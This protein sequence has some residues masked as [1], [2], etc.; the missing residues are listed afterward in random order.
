MRLEIDDRMAQKA[1]VRKNALI[2]GLIGRDISLRQTLLVAFAW[3]VLLFFSLYRLSDYPLIWFDEGSHLHVPKAL[4][5]MGAYADYSSEGLRYFGPTN[6]VG[7]TVMLPVAA[8]FKLF[9]IGLI[10]ARLVV[11]LYLLA[12]IYLFHRLASHL[13]GKSLALAGILL[14]VAS[15]GI[16]IVEYGRQVLG[17]VPALVFL[18]SGIL[19]WWSAWS[20]PSWGKLSLAGVLLG[21]S[22]VTKTQFLL[23]V[24]PAIALAWLAN[25]IHY[26]L[27][28]H[29]V[30]LI[31]GVI[32]AFMFA[33]W[34]FVLLFGIDPQAEFGNLALL[35]KTSGSA[36]FVFSL[37]L[38]KRS[39]SELLSIRG[40]FGLAVWVLLYGV[41]LIMPKRVDA[42]KWATLWLMAVIN[43]AWY[44]F[45]SVSWLR[46][47]FVGL[48]FSCLFLG[49][50][51]IELMDGF[52]ARLKSS[53]KLIRSG[54]PVSG[55]DF[56]RF[57]LI[58]IIVGS[59]VSSLG[60]NAWQVLRPRENP[61]ELMADYMQRYVPLTAVVETY[62]P[63]MGFLTNHRYHFPPHHYLNETI[64]SIW[65]EGSTP[66]SDYD[67]IAEERP[68]Y[69]L[70]GEFST[71][72]NFYSITD[73]EQ[74]YTLVTAIGPY[75]LYQIKS[76]N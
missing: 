56:L 40:Y 55:M 25:M 26:R 57:S 16:L 27:L 76:A 71:W 44:V 15:R 28:P 21:L 4:V 34:Q 62:E 3:A 6:G 30:F 47:A 65:M 74:S 64:Q 23:F 67:F 14:L 2:E 10:Q 7:P 20:K 58:L 70:V 37:D 1:Q 68:D 75:R 61:P 60:M 5:L 32:T 63:E 17:E 52:S 33:V 43:I 39:A 53:W 48:A 22:V 72:V 29:R 41:S 50:L 46:Y 13:G 42:L 19:V 66:G 35:T 51:F 11:V 24:G 12:S 49:K 73:L 9:G 54:E 31:P 38:I 36:A 8:M 69:V 59:G 45:A 18:L